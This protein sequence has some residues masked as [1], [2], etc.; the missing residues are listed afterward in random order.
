MVF[1][2]NKEDKDEKYAGKITRKNPRIKGAY[3]S[4]L[5]MFLHV[6]ILVAV[7]IIQTLGAA[8]YNDL[9]SGIL[10]PW[11]QYQRSNLK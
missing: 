2:K 5:D 7:A 6:F 1:K 8:T 10:I 3:K 9:S 4:Y 11:M